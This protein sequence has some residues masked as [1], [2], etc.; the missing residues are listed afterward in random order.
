MREVAIVGGGPA[1]ALC[2]ERLA[3]AG[4]RVTVFD[5]HLAWEKPCGGGL[6]YKALETYPFLLEGPHPKKIVQTAELISSRGD[7]ARL[8]LARPTAIYS[9]TVLN[10]LLLERARAAGCTLVKQ[11]VTRMDVSRPQARLQAGADEHAADFVVVA[12]GARNSLLPETTPLRVE[13]LEITSGY[14]LPTFPSSEN[15]HSA[16]DDAQDVMKVKFL[17]GFNGYLWSFPRPDHL[18]VGIC[19]PMRGNTSRALMQ[20]VN[21]FVEEEKLNGHRRPNGQ[22]AK[23]FSHLLPSPRPRTIRERRVMGRNWALVGD[24]AAWV[25]PLTGEG[26][27]YAMR[28]GDLLGQALAR[29][30]AEDYVSQVR[31]EF[32]GEFEWAVRAAHRFFDGM[33]FGRPMIMR[34]IQ[35]LRHSP[36]LRLIAGELFSGEQNYSTLKKRLLRRAAVVLAEVVAS[37]VTG[38]EQAKQEVASSHRTPAA[39]SESPFSKFS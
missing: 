31:S 11:R 12:A 33:F 15:G 13:D 36:A 23:V 22:E 26:L 29:G 35:F 24:A 9:R 16:N 28:S 20:R 7:R 5:E 19:G 32:C 38:R 6:T 2:G 17:D 14:F 39:G 8:E 34:M 27:Y 10:G 37:V 4:F 18:S 1:G 25:D 30:R 3:E 21:E